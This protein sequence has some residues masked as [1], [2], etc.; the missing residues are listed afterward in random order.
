MNAELVPP[1]GIW[2]KINSAINVLE[3]KQPGKKAVVILRRFA[4]AAI[5]IGLIVTAWIVFRNNNERSAG[6]AEETPRETKIKTDTNS[7]KQEKDNPKNIETS[8]DEP[9][10]TTSIASI[11][12][13]SAGTK[14]RRNKNSFTPQ[15]VKK[16]QLIALNTTLGK[17]FHQPIDDLSRVT[18]DQHYLTMVNSNGRLI[19]IPAQLAYL[20]PHLQ[21]KPIS[22]DIYEIMFGEGTYWK[23][24]LNEWRKK[25]ASS[26]VASGDA[27]ASLVEMLKTIQDK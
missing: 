16:G 8:I 2:E 9:S 22:E 17:S 4:A 12:S 18:A 23:E 19:K 21:D 3:E 1:A 27:F 11:I 5:F 14:N 10:A 26:P 25:V 6:L 24:T 13:Q 7:T 20:A 15:L